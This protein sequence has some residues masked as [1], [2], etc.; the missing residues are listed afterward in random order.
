LLLSEHL[1]AAYDSE[2]EQEVDPEENEKD[3]DVWMD[4][5]MEDEEAPL[6]MQSPARKCW[7]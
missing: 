5:W 2:S 4:Q 1:E 7:E 6:S 3:E